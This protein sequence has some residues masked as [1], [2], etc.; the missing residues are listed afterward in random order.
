MGVGEQRWDLW[1]ELRKRDID[2]LGRKRDKKAHHVNTSQ[3]LRGHPQDNLAEIRAMGTQP[4]RGRIPENHPLGP[5]KP[6]GE[7]V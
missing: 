5:W 4:V 7:F 1:G 6:P 3:R 2:K